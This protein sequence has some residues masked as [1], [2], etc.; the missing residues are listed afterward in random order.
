MKSIIIYLYF[1]LGAAQNLEL[2]ISPFIQNIYD[3]ILPYRVFNSELVDLIPD[4]IR[5]VELTRYTFI[6]GPSI[7]NVKGVLPD[8]QGVYG[9]V[10]QR[11][12]YNIFLIKILDTILKRL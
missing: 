9:L 3:Q 8:P 7:R 6:K 1:N 5:L 4:W 2:L 12:E 11:L 10:I